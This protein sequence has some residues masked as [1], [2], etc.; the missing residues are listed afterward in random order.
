MLAGLNRPVGLLVD[1]VQLPKF[2]K[3]TQASML[4]FMVSKET[5]PETIEKCD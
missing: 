5:Q 3:Q 4:E 2:S 1:K